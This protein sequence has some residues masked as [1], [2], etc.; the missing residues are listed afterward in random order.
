MAELYI[1]IDCAEANC[2]LC[3]PDLHRCDHWCHYDADAAVASS[4][5]SDAS[6]LAGRPALA[7]DVPD[8]DG[9]HG[10]PA[11]SESEDDGA[12]DQCAD[13]VTGDFGEVVAHTPDAPASGS[14]P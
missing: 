12:A 8:A 10:S 3:R 14:T 11:S 13:P 7:A 2:H 1:S 6:A 4:S 5:D 9:L